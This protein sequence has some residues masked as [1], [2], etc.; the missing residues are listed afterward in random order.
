MA[1]KPA[2]AVLHGTLPPV[3]QPEQD[4]YPFCVVWTPIPLLSW[5]LPFV[6]HVGICDSLG[7]VYDFQGD[8]RIGNDHLLFGRPVKYWDLSREYCPT[9]YDASVPEGPAKE[10]R[11]R[12]EIEQYDAA[13]ANATQHFRQTQPYNLLFNN[14]HVYVAAGANT[15]TL[16]RKHQNAFTIGIGMALHGRYVSLGRFLSAHVPFFIVVLLFIIAIKVFF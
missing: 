5:V 4:H 3:M 7:R 9:F 15:Q 12:R 13:I 14:C 2:P 16:N 1:M 6:G 8:Y 11:V 10:E